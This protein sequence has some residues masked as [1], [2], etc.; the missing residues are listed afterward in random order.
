MLAQRYPTAYDGIAAGAPGIQWTDF[1][2]TMF[3]PQQVMNMLGE[4]PSSCELQAVTAAVVSACDKLD[5]VVDG[6]IADVDKCLGTFDPFTLVGQKLKCDNGQE[7][8]EAV[9]SEAAAVVANATWQ[10]RRNAQ[11]VQVWSG[12]D[13][14]TDLTAGV[15][16]T[17]CTSGTCEGVPLPIATQWLT[18]F[19]ARDPDFDLSNLTH[20][21]FDWLAHQGKQRYNSFIG[22]DDPDLSVFRGNG[23]KLVTFHGLVSVLSIYLR[24]SSPRKEDL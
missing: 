4:Y 22:T 5:G 9:I 23:G 21:E 3:W 18:L 17:D 1:F 11:G 13:P 6:I 14:G 7:K 15:A 24:G 16:T 12:L 10:G 19:V 8:S 2:P 20:A